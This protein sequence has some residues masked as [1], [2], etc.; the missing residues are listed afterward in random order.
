MP[1]KRHLPCSGDLGSGEWDS[2]RSPGGVC[3]VAAPRTPTP[4]DPTLLLG[5]EKAWGSTWPLRRRT[6]VPMV[7]T[8]SPARSQAVTG[9]GE[10]ALGRSPDT[11]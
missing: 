9:G 6:T 10:D 8:P 1:R 5:P 3:V 2:Q 11:P 7:R 4:S